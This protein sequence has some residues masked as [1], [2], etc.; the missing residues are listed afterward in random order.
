MSKPHKHL[1]DPPPGAMRA[2]LFR[3]RPELPEPRPG[4]FD[5]KRV[6]VVVAPTGASGRDVRVLADRLSR[7]GA[8]MGVASE[9]H[10]EARDEHMRPIYPH[11]LLV[12]IRPADWDLLVFA[13][14][15]GA[16]RVAEDQLAQSIARAFVAAGKPVA[17]IGNGAAVLRAARI[18]GHFFDDVLDLLRSL[19]PGAFGLEPS[20]TSS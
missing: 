13:G 19:E 20:P 16:L 11:R 5:G 3:E 8:V 9:C 14:G 17:G 2:V 12:E 1:Y 4:P 18:A 7:E 15:H 10:G 6:L